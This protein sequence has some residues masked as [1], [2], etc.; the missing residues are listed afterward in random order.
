MRPAA[1]GRPSRSKELG[2]GLAGW[3]KVARII[4][5]FHIDDLHD[6]RYGGPD[7]KHLL[8]A[9]VQISSFLPDADLTGTRRGFASV[10]F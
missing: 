10:R 4:S 7:L 3:L 6:H 5:Y 1:P 9:E 8:F 2:H